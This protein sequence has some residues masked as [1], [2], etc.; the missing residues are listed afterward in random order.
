[1]IVPTEMPA[2]S[3]VDNFFVYW[4]PLIEL[5]PMVHTDCANAVLAMLP[6]PP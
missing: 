2:V 1:M 3:P 6:Q 5:P 4:P